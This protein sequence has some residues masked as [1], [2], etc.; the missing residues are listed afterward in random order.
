MNK[1]TDI[2]GF[3]TSQLWTVESSK[4]NSTAWIWLNKIFFEKVTCENLLVLDQSSAYSTSSMNHL[5]LD[6]R[7][8]SMVS[9]Q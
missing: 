8:N 3:R 6:L 2:E 5:V 7:D 4:N 1:N 9:Q